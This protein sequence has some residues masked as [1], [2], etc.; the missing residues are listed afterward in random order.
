MF[1]KNPIVKATERCFHSPGEQAVA[2]LESLLVEEPAIL[3]EQC[4]LILQTANTVLEEEGSQLADIFQGQGSP[5]VCRM[6]CVGCCQQLVLCQSFEARNIHKYLETN[7]LKKQAFRES[8]RLWDEGTAHLRDSYLA[9]AIN[10]YGRDEDSGSHVF[11]DYQAPCPFLNSEKLCDI[12]PVRPYGCRTCI[13]LDPACAT[14]VEGQKRT[15][16]MMQYS[17]YTTHHAAR[18]AVTHMLLRRLGTEA[19]PTPM[20]SVLANLCFGASSTPEA[21]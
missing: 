1:E 5:I 14:P 13:A 15:L 8:Y 2:L 19:N 12:Y 10:Y 17:L 11:E 3:M 21:D 6:G 4:L 18:M 9:W 16:H 7:P 20:P